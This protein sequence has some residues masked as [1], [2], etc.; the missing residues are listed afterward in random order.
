MY[1]RWRCGEAG[2]YIVEQLA[3]METYD[4]SKGGDRWLQARVDYREATTLGDYDGLTWYAMGVSVEANGEW[5]V[6]D[7]LQATAWSGGDELTAFW[8]F[9]LCPRR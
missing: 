9:D 5:C 8:R 1:P 4:K 2:S 6:C 7:I 3:A